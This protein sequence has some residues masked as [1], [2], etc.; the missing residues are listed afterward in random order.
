MIHQSLTHRVCPHHDITRHTAYLSCVHIMASLPGRAVRGGLPLGDAAAADAGG[1]R[2]RQ[3]ARHG[4]GDLQR[5]SYLFSCSLGCLLC[6]CMWAV[7]SACCPMR[8]FPLPSLPPFEPPYYTNITPPHHQPSPLQQ[9][10]IIG[11]TAVGL[12]VTLLMSLCLLFG[13][14][15][16]PKDSLL[17]AKFQVW[18]QI[19]RMEEGRVSVVWHVVE[20]IRTDLNPRGKTVSYVARVGVGGVCSGCVVASVGSVWWSWSCEAFGINPRDLT[21]SFLSTFLET[22]RPTRRAAR[23]IRSK[24]E[25][26]RQRRAEAARARGERRG[27]LLDF[28]T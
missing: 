6:M 13:A 8:P 1:G 15:A 26:R 28:F 9:V 17:Y 19:T 20:S 16:G 11:W 4:R 18:T 12:I 5:A 24:K 21:A 10:N 7:P 22:N 3:R 27:V 25:G 14:D 2:R 23:W